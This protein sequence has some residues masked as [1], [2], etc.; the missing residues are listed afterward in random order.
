MILRAMAR[1]DEA[2]RPAR[3]RGQALAPLEQPLTARSGSSAAVPVARS[4]RSDGSSA[5]SS[6]SWPWLP[7]RF[8]HL[9][10]QASLHRSEEPH[11]VWFMERT[12]RAK[13]GGA[14]PGVAMSGKSDRL[15]YG[16]RSWSEASSPG[17]GALA[18]LRAL[19]LE[20]PLARIYPRCQTI[21]GT[22][23]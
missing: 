15:P 20:D 22:L 8:M 3:S 7:L 18:S 11:K 10:K 2:A 9:A 21:Q 14:S 13:A 4:M 5:A 12:P 16:H 23:S 19:R 17:H 6:S 1:S